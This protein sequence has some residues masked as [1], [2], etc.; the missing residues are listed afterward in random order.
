METGR[1]ERYSSGELR[2]FSMV[3]DIEG[4]WI[5]A[6]PIDVSEGGMMVRLKKTPAESDADRAEAIF[7]LNDRMV[8]VSCRIAWKGRRTVNEMEAFCMGLNADSQGEW[9]TEVTVAARHGLRVSA[10]EQ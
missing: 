7:F 8:R 3:L 2:R 10:E 9:P 6:V 5:A 4:K 1:R